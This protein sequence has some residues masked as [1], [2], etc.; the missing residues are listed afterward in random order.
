MTRPR[1]VQFSCVQARIRGEKT[2]VELAE[3]FKVH[4]NQIGEWRAELMKRAAEISVTT[5]DKRNAVPELRALHTKIGQPPLEIAFACRRAW[6]QRRCERK[7]MI[8][9][10]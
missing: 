3:Q 2:L 7:A 4:C 5:A 8:N 10:S 9:P 1:R 6:P